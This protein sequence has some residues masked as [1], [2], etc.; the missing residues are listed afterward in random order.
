M[1]CSRTLQTVFET[2]VTFQPKALSTNG[3][4]TISTSAPPPQPLWVLRACPWMRS[5]SLTLTSPP[6]D[7]ETPTHLSSYGGGSS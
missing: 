4:T 3:V 7:P 2:F 5:H 6:V 1:T